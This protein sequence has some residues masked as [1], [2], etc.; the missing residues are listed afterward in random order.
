MMLIVFV[1]LGVLLGWG[2]HIHLERRRLPRCRAL[3]SN[4]MRCEYNREHDGPHTVNWNG[5]EF[6]WTAE[7]QSVTKLVRL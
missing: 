1:L 7:E 3:L 5:R 2:L 4:G 6:S